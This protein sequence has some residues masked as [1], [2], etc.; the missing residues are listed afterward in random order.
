MEI[1]ILLLLIQPILFIWILYKAI[2]NVNKIVLN[3]NQES[4]FEHD[5]WDAL[6]IITTWVIPIIGFLVNYGDRSY[7]H[8]DSWGGDD[9]FSLFA[10]KYIP[11]MALFYFVSVAILYL[12]NYIGKK[13][14]WLFH[15]SNAMLVLII[16]ISALASIQL[17]S[18]GLLLTA[19]SILGFLL[20]VPFLNIIL[21]IRMY[22]IKIKGT[23]S[24]AQNTLIAFGIAIVYAALFQFILHQFGFNEFGLIKAFTESKDGFIPKII[25]NIFN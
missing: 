18:M 24:L 21:L 17:G 15:T 9:M 5:E 11:E 2:K 8:P 7:N 4:I 25:T 16:T 12:G 23:E 19:T 14:L 10:P 6:T 1:T 13:Q 22:L 20:F 3:S